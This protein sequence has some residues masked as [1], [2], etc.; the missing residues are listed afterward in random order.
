M[1]STATATRTAAANVKSGD[2]LITHQLNGDTA[3]MRVTKVEFLDVKVTR[4]D[5]V[6]TVYPVAR[7]HGLGS[8]DYAPDYPVDI[9]QF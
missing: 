5:G 8:V 6:T 4:M 3:R 7:I 9:I 1:T 2:I